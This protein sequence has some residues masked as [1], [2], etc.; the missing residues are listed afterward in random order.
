MKDFVHLH[1][2]SEYSLLDGACRVK[3]IPKIA[4]ELGQSAVAITDHGNMYGAVAFYKACKKEGVKPIIGCE[5]YMAAGDRTDRHK[6]PSGDNFHL[7]LLVKND[8]G[9][10]NL[11]TLVSRSY[12]E[13]FYIKPRVDMSLLEKHHEGLVCLSGCLGGR[14]PQL[15]LSGD[16]ASARDTARRF[17]EI[18]GEDYYLE[19]QDHGIPDQKEV[20]RELVEISKELDIP[21]VCTNDAHYLR[22]ADADNQAVL[23]CIQM[24]E[25]ILDGRPL[26]FEGDEFYIKSRDEMEELFNYVPEALNNTVRIA[27]KCNFDFEFGKLH[28]P[29]YITPDN[30][31]SSDYLRSLVQRR[32]AKKIIN[33]EIIFTD[34]HP[35]E[36][37]KERLEYEL[38]IIRSM[39]YCD[40]FLIVWDF[41]NHAKENGIPVG[42]GRGS[43][44][45][46]L[47]AFILGI[48]EVDSIKFDLLFERFLNPE[49]VSMP[50]IDT[51]FC[52]RR[53]G[54]VIDYVCEK[55]GH[56]NVS[57][58]TTFGTMAARAVV[59]DVGRALGMPYG[60]VDEVAK[61]IP[62]ELNITLSA[63]LERTP[64][65]RSLYESD[66]S[67]SRLIDIS[68]ALEGMP[69]HASTHAAGVV[70]TEKP[71]REYV[72][73][74]V[75]ED[76]PLTQF[77]METV[78]DLG[79]L[80]FDF[81]G[82]R[83]LTIID[84]C[85]KLVRISEPGFNVKQAPLDDKG[86]FDMLS[87]GRT[88]GVFQLESAGMRQTLMQL[89]PGNINDVM[90]AIA[91][92]RPGPVKSIPKYISNKH[93]PATVDYKSPLLRDILSS[94]YGCIV[95]QEQV[96]QIF[97]ALA[98]YSFGRADIVR[99]A[100]SKKKADVL[101]NEK[102]SFVSGAVSTGLEKEK[103][104]A[105]YEEMADFA[106]YAFNK[107]HAA[108]YSFVSYRT[109]FLKCHY[110]AQYMAALLTSVI[111]DINKTA[112]YI[113]VCRKE[114]IRVIPPHVNESSNT[115][116]VS[117]G[118]IYYSLVALKNLGEKFVM[119]ITNERERNGRFVSFEDF[120]ERMSEYDLNKKQV[121][122]LIMCG[123][124]D[125]LGANRRQLL[126]VFEPF[127]DS[128]I[129]KKRS[130]LAGQMDLF[131]MLDE[132]PSGNL[133][134]PQMSDFSLREK[135]SL[136][137]N[138]CGISLSGSILD[139][140][141][142]NI[143]D[144]KYADLASIVSYDETDSDS[145]TY[146]DKQTVSVVGVVSKIQA[147]DTRS[148]ERMLFVTLEDASYQIEVLVF[149]KLL[150]THG[151]LFTTDSCLFLKGN[152][153]LK[154]GER[155]KLLASDALPLI[156]N[157]K[158]VKARVN[159]VAATQKKALYIRVL[160]TRADN[161]SPILSALA[162]E[163]GSV[164]VI[165]YDSSASKYVKAVGVTTSASERILSAL[166][167][168]CGEN[169]VILKES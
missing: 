106:K 16:G 143:A 2:H 90:A 110:P 135:L 18:F 15:I 150:Q 25:S 19:L 73:V 160:N 42:P 67:V 125:G 133:N 115:Y 136:E 155:P 34:E 32:F 53:R 61:L 152:I 43:G 44:A 162:K 96:M 165:F 111:G 144:L 129:E 49:R 158:Y 130:G 81:L 124:F 77:D 82:L 13:G 101:E 145:Y 24:N 71:T 50:D 72:P 38:G 92:Y 74:S 8:V 107:S 45:G 47:V 146:R 9:Y 26:G 108:A 148:G 55:Y 35:V 117:D 147:K 1:L 153:S 132:R 12:T 122:T 98:G 6:N 3:D 119:N 151:Y 65:L 128:V 75:N 164:P 22:R 142:D 39:G 7:V 23:M 156:E 104:E 11:I 109:A 40:Y 57:Q 99:K 33:Q 168:L 116:T 114:G 86:T 159:H 5:V 63:A 84:D 87:S 52:Y 102:T 54:E 91:L 20:N 94:T 64:E 137:K 138:T 70:I 89:K 134:I 139:E 154:E 127:V 29:A 169:N 83:Y 36:E 78:A 123:A 157:G 62:R 10:K 126:S 14:I 76:M 100:M 167:E 56:D 97:R 105:L 48:T 21:L 85:E 80:K 41:I 69:R 28:L 46:S 166:K 27:E 120:V 88:D 30:T 59:R 51:D 161:V 93:N 163:S 68:K 131:S 79:L 113:G 121:E 60:T 58:I 66:S 118:K 17:K 141:S 103:A 140:Y 37:Y 4:K 95:Y 31:D 112:E 149:P